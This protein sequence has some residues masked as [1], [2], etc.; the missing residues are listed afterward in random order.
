MIRRIRENFRCT[1]A[2]CYIG[3]VTQAVVN[4]F[5]TLLFVRFRTEFGI[6]LGQLGIIST[7][8]F[9]TQLTLDFASVK[10]V[11]ALGYRVCSVAAHLLSA[12]GLL[13]LTVLP[14]VMPH[15]FVGILISVVIYAIGGGLMEVLLSPMVEA[16]PVDN[17]EA[18]MS[19][20]HSFYCWGCVLVIAVS[21]AFFAVAGLDKWRV[22]AALWALIPAA[23]AI[24]FLF[25]PIRALVEDGQEMRVGTMLKNPVFWLMLM[26]M[27]AAGASEMGMSQW[28]S[29]FAEAG[30]GVSKTAGDLL[31][32]CL[33][34]VLMG[35][36]RVVHARL[37]DRIDIRTYL[38]GSAALCVLCY[39]AAGLAKAPVLGLAACALTGASIGAMWPGTFSFASRTLPRGGTAMF[40]LLA[41]AGD[42]GC[43]A[44]PAVVGAVS[45]AAGGRLSAGLLSGVVFPAVMLVCL[46]CER[47]GRTSKKE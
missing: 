37:A 7:V 46:V 15:P 39:L 31:G 11:D 42:L 29:A 5:V 3:F 2:A 47:A 30:L 33:F 19:I 24:F 28:S 40:A 41:L 6:T 18:T 44:G 22:M 12:G 26:L 38:T 1:I 4:V 36:S 9:V 23:N 17:K 21:T 25:V 45:E 8:N 34:A 10:V 14:G 16:C 20:L 35:S 43:S 32:P 27:F 13:L